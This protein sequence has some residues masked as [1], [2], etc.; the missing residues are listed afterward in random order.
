MIRP[1][2]L[3]F[4][5][6]LLWL[7]A[8]TAAR[9]LPIAEESFDYESDSPMAGLAGGKGW[10]GGWFVS[11]LHKSD[12]RVTGPGLSFAGLAGGGMKMKQVGNDVRSFR[13]IDVTRK[14]VSGLV[15]DGQ[16]GKTL[17]KAGTSIW[18]GFLIAVSSYPK[19]AYGGIHLCDGLGDLTKDPFGDKQA[20]QRISMGRSNMSKNWYLGRVTNGGPGAGKWES[21][22]RAD[23][24]VR[25]L[26]YR[27]D[28]A[29][30]GVTAQLFIDPMPGRA[31]ADSSAKI[32]AT[33]VTPFRFN[34]LSVGS[35][36][37]AEFYLD[38]IRI[39]SEFADVA[40]A[41]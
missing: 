10:D 24:T 22:V 18:I 23:T 13:K 2:T 14:E 31:P 29:A 21:D 27:L 17:G 40:P 4:A 8:A 9:A 25:L 37:G 20:H 36:G 5:T 38:E 3:V 6:A 26:V 11:P 19:V 34:T 16:Y 39:G 35:G 7:G 1:I 33:N 30:N 15:V 41:K 12:N 32:T 28:F